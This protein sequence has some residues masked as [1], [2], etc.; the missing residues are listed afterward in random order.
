[1]RSSEERSMA[2]AKLYR[3]MDGN[4]VANN[5]LEFYNT[6]S[7]KLGQG[8]LN[9]YMEPGLIETYNEGPGNPGFTIT[10][11]VSKFR[12]GDVLEVDTELQDVTWGDRGYALNPLAYH[13]P[14]GY[15][16]PYR[17]FMERLPKE[18]L[19]VAAL[20]KNIV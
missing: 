15:P 14:V 10:D 17:L 16:T 5:E 20:I 3:S 13:L 6:G 7:V 1:M 9:V 2:A 12:T 4:I 11:F 8:L 19:K 18:V